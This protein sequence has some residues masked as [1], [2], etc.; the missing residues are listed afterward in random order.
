MEGSS[1]PNTKVIFSP[2]ATCSNTGTPARRHAKI[3]CSKFRDRATRAPRAFRTPRL[4]HASPFPSG[5]HSTLRQACSHL[6]NPDFVTGHQ[7]K[8]QKTQAKFVIF[9]FWPVPLTRL[10]CLHTTTATI[11]RLGHRP[12]KPF[13]CFSLCHQLKTTNFV[14]YN[15]TNT[16][17][18][19]TIFPF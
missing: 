10:P 14:T 13:L 11:F 2:G 8:P 19:S 17:A 12:N 5:A 7:A 3:P 18:K 16:P 9:P 6:C 15:I 1:L 4:S